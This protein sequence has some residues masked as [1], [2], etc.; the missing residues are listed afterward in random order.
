MAIGMIVLV[1]NIIITTVKNKRV[2]NDPW[3]DG[4]TLEWAIPSPPPFYNFAQT[5]LVRGLDT[6]WIEKMEGN[7]SGI[8]PAEP[9]ARY[10]YAKWFIY[11]IHDVIRF[12]HCWIWCNVP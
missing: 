9:V 8:T 3:E 12:V 10:S 5:P 6:Y 2:G 4:R 7:K 1:I 11:S